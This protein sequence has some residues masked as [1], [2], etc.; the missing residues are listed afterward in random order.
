MEQAIGGASVKDS[1]RSA[2]L[3]A[4]VAFALLSVGDAIVKGMAG[5]WP[6]TA[7]AALRYG[8]GCVGLGVIT[9]VREGR[10]GLSLPR[11]WWQVLRGFAV[12]LSAVCFFSALQFMPIGEATAILFTSPM[13]TALLAAVVLHEPLRRE[14]WIASGLAFLGVLLV[15]RPNFALLGWAA[16]LPMLAALGMAALMIANRKV[17]GTGSALSMQVNVAAFGAL[18]LIVATALG[19]ASGIAMLSVSWPS[20]GVIL[21]CALIAVTASVAHACLYLATT[22]V[23]ASVIAP[24]TYVQLLMAGLFGWLLFGETPDAMALTGALTIVGAGLYLWRAGQS[25]QH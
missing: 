6:G 5:Q 13:M 3:L 2:L 7:I 18:F 4:I 9:V 12:S 15:L 20:S 8:I 11:P 23:G 22:R 14:T 17:A 21:R 10:S 19:H 25:R 16:L 1:Y 24:M